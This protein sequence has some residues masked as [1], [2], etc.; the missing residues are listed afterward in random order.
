[1]K[2]VVYA[3]FKDV[4]EIIRDDDGTEKDG[5]GEPVLLGLYT[6]LEQANRETADQALETV[7]PS[8]SRRIDDITKRRNKDLELMELMKELA[9]KGKPYMEEMRLSDNKKVQFFVVQS[10]LVGP[11]NI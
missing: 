5:P 7:A 1:M 10:P 9:E 8:G 11:R 6:H 2:K 3:A 4:I